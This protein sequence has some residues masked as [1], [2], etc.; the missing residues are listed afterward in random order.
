M[1]STKFTP[2]TKVAFGIISI[3]IQVQPLFA[4]GIFPDETLFKTSEPFPTGKI[5]FRE[6]WVYHYIDG[7]AGV[8]QKSG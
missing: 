2:F 8:R 6:D 7:N 4:I 3:L 5:K 1:K